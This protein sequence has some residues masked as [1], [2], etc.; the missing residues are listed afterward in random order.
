MHPE[1]FLS[2]MLRNKARGNLT[3]KFA[4]K[5]NIM[6]GLEEQV[7]GR[8]AFSRMLLFL[9]NGERGCSLELFISEYKE[10]NFK[11]YCHLYHHYFP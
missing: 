7:Y 2:A 6:Q 11:T 9:M 5:E 4:C 10:R 1:W 8:K 3:D